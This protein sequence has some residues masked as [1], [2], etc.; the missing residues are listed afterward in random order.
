MTGVNLMEMMQEIGCFG[1][2]Y[3]E[4]VIYLIYLH[5]DV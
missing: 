4:N 2:L 5:N 3:N 1:Y